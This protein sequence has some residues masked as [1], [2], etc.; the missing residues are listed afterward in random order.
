MAHLDKIT[1]LFRPVQ[2]KDSSQKGTSQGSP[3]FDN[4]RENIDPNI[5]TKSVTTKEIHLEDGTGAGYV[6]NAADGTL[7]GGNSLQSLAEDI[8]PAIDDTYDLGSL[9]KKWAFIYATIAVL[10]SIVIGGVIGLQNIDEILF[11]NATTN[12]SSDVY[13]NG[14]L[15]VGT[16]N[17]DTTLHIK[18]KE[19]LVVFQANIGDRVLSDWKD[20][21]DVVTWVTD[22]REDRYNIAEDA[23]LTSNSRFYIETG[24]QIGMG[25]VTPAAALHIKGTGTLN[26]GIKLEASGSNAVSEIQFGNSAD[27]WF[28][29]ID[30]SEIFGI[31]DVQS[32]NGQRLVITQNGDVGIGTTTPNF[33]LDVAGKINSSNPQLNP[34]YITLHT[35]VNQSTIV[36]VWVNISLDETSPVKKGIIHDHI[37]LLN[38]S[39]N[40]TTSGIYVIEYF[41][42]FEDSAANPT[43]SAAVRVVADN[44]EI[45]GSLKEDDLTKQNS[46]IEIS[47][48]VIANLTAP[49]I[50]NVQFISDTSTVSLKSHENFG[51]HPNTLVLDIFRID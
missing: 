26:P 45:E 19:L 20:Q 38:T 27:N 50:L 44:V 32:Q 3:G 21:S 49:V 14:S 5:R 37:G 6:K 28:V 51:V 25:T 36:D 31:S 41:A 7:S 9:S 47:D 13:I 18:G 39:I 23:P 29:G 17:P 11:V 30:G 22:I 40:I 10:G 35:P 8:I 2:N 16:D 12:F 4:L 1:R 15:G 42:N 46:D 43:S 24:G 33:I 48:A 34:Q